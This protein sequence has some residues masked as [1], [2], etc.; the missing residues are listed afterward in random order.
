MTA[1]TQ[2]IF[3]SALALPPTDR[4]S[5][6][7]QLLASFDREIRDSIDPLW[8]EE[9]EL[10]L[11]AYDRGEIRAHDLVDVVALINKR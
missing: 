4:A 1:D 6:I 5:L 7:E 3:T 9:S 10:R 2:K 8:A 11:D